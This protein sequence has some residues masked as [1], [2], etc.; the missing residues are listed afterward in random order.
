MGIAM[1]EHDSATD[2]P[3]GFIGSMSGTMEILSD[4]ISPIDEEWDADAGP[5]SAGN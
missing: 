5:E 2:R 3:L 4:I 1:D